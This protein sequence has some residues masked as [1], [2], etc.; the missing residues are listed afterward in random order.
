MTVAATIAG[1]LSHLASMAMWGAMFGG[2]RHSDSDED[3]AREFGADEAGALISGNPIPLAN[4]L[5]KLERTRDTRALEHASPATAHL[6]IV[7]PF[8]GEGLM[9][10]FRTHPPAEERIARLESMAVGYS[11]VPVP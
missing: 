2:G 3:R 8:S 6:F 9:K 5:R 4:A 1:A 10:L 7:N 11:P